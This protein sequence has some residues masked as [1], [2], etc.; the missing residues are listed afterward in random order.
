MRSVVD[1]SVVMRRMTVQVISKQ[2][3]GIM[4]T[5]RKKNGTELCSGTQHILYIAENA[6]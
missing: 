2:C 4:S 1:R 6:E 3:V 5:S